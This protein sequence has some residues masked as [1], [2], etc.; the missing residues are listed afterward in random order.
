MLT[1]HQ[2]NFITD[3]SAEETEV[4]RG[5]VSYQDHSDAE[6]GLNSGFLNRSL[7]S[8]SLGLGGLSGSSF[9]DPSHRP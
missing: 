1:P 8:S 2:S 3:F 9:S 7:P 5:K 4:Q 6:R